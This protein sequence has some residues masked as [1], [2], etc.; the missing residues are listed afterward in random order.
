MMLCVVEWLLEDEPHLPEVLLARFAEAH[1]PWRRYGSGTDAIL[2]QFPKYKS[3]WREFATAMFPFGSYGNGSA[4][5]VAP[6]GLAFHNNIEKAFALAITSSRPT[7]SHAFAY[8][9]V[10]LQTIAVAIAASSLKFSADAFLGRMRSALVTFSELMQDTSKY[11]RALNEIEAGLRRGTSCREMS[12]VLGTGVTAQE[13][14]PMAIYCFLRHPES[15][16]QVIHEAVFIG[17]DT[18]TIACMAGAISGAFL[19]A[20]AIPV[21]WLRNIREEKYTFGA[22]E[23]LADRLFSKFV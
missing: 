23:L 14:V 1:E 4:M 6:I 12:E 5:R 22:I 15:Y 10:V 9:G 20:S 16:A 7:H 18:D 13:A 11:E 8:H 2:R 17:G 21:N 3:E 19:G